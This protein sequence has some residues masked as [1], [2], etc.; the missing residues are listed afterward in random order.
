MVKLESKNNYSYR[1]SYYDKNTGK[2]IREYKDRI[3]DSMAKA[4]KE[5]ERRREIQIAYNREHNITPTTIKKEIND[6]IRGKETQMMARKYLD[7]HHKQDK[8]EKERLI[9]SLEK[10]MKEAARVLDFE[11]AAELR[12]VILELKSN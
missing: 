1:A 4:M 3:T 12:D 7:K 11:R 2:R 8:K 10:E 5:T 6:V 9:E